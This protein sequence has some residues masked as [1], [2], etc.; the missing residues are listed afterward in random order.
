MRKIRFLI[1]LL[2]PFL[3][4]D[5]STSSGNYNI[6]KPGSVAN[7][8]VNQTHQSINPHSLFTLTEAEKVLG[9]GAHLT[10]SSFVTQGD[11]I[12]YQCAFTENASDE[13]SGKTGIVYFMFEEYKQISSAKKMYESIRKANESH[14]GVKEVHDLGDEA[15]FHSDGL[16]LFYS[17]Q[18]R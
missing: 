4:C 3:G 9:E 16:N 7:E 17:Y 6:P 1:T 15:Y 8:K 5:P 12:K 11:P 10:D 18:K 2:L 13:K 14:E